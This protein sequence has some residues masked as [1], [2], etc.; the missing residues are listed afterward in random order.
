MILTWLDPGWGCIPSGR[1]ES[2]CRRDASNGTGPGARD[3]LGFGIPTGIICQYACAWL[4]VKA[5]TATKCPTPEGRGD[6]ITAGRACQL[7]GLRLPCQIHTVGIQEA[8]S[9]SEASFRRS[10]SKQRDSRGKTARQ[11]SIPVS[12][13]ACP[14]SHVPQ[15][16]DELAH[17][18]GQAEPAAPVLHRPLRLHQD[19]LARQIPAHPV[20]HALRDRHLRPIHLQGHKCVQPP[21]WRC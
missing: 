11:L 18:P 14:L 20:R 13:R 7:A 4:R 21:G 16:R 6:A 5:T 15:L 17:Q 19:Q 9:R 3:R 1:L 2:R 8:K 10:P 12:C